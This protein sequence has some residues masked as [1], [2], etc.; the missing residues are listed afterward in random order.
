MTSFDYI[1]VK[2][3]C[4]RLVSVHNGLRVK[5]MDNLMFNLYTFQSGEA[6]VHSKMFLLFTDNIGTV[7]LYGKRANLFDQIGWRGADVSI[8][9]GLVLTAV[10]GVVSWY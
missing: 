6:Y 2:Q 9:T 8:V 7:C 1:R 4:N 3:L 5:N 10:A